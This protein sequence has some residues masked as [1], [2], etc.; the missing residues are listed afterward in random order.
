MACFQPTAVCDVAFPPRAAELHFQGW[1]PF[2]MVTSGH[3]LLFLQPPHHTGPLQKPFTFPSIIGRACQGPLLVTL[4]LSMSL[5]HQQIH[6]SSHV[7]CLAF[8]GPN[9]SPY[10]CCPVSASP[11]THLSSDLMQAASQT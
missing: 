7:S 9:R 3:C 11:Q 5:L 1:L 8:Q 10:G 4:P 2:Q 6:G